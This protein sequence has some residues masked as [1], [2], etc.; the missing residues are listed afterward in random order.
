MAEYAEKYIKLSRFTPEVMMNELKKAR[1]SEKRLRPELY[2]QVAV[3][4]LSTYQ[5]ILMKA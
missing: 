4:T 2:H 1:R 5:A 3:F